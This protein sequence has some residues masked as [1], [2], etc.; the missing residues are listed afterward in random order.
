MVPSM[1]GGVAMHRSG[2]SLGSK[3]YVFL[4]C[5]FVTAVV[6]TLGLTVRPCAYATEPNSPHGCEV[7]IHI[8]PYY[9]MDAILVE[10]D[11]HFG[12]IDSGED[13]LYPNG[14]DGYILREGV[15][16]SAG[17]EREL[18]AYM[19]SVGV[20]RGN[21]DFYIGTHAHSDHIGT[22]PFVLAEFQP[23]AVYTPYYADE[24][25]SNKEKLWDNLYVYDK[26]CAAVEAY[27]GKLVHYL[28]PAWNGEG[29]SGDGADDDRSSQT[30]RPSFV[31]GDAVVEIMNYESADLDYGTFAAPDANNYSYGVK[32]IAPN[33][34][35]AFLSGDINDKRDVDEQI[36]GGDETRLAKVLQNVDFLKL[37]HHG[38]SGSNTPDY[39][40][41]ILRPYS[42]DERAVVVQTG[43]YYRLP[44]NTLNTLHSLGVRYFCA[45]HAAGLGLEAFVATLGDS[46]VSTNMDNAFTVQ[47]R[48]SAPWAYAYENGVPV[49]GERGFKSY[50]QSTYYFEDDGSVALGWR[51]VGDTWY[52]FD[53]S[54]GRRKT[55]WLKD[56]STWYFLDASG[57]MQTGWRKVNGSWYYLEG[58]G[59]MQTGWLQ[60]GSRW[61]YL[62]KS[63]A[64]AEGWQRNGG[65]WYYL[66]PGSGVMATGWIR[67]GGQWYYLKGSGAMAQGWQRVGG[68]WYYLNGS[69][70]MAEGWKK[71]SGTWYYLNPGS[72]TMATGWL[73]Y[74]GSWYYLNSSGAMS[75]GP[76]VIGGQVYRFS[77]SGAMM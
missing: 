22:A 62:G 24:L 48:K 27:G 55:G 39:L 26:L 36:G 72:G 12:M 21:L 44:A 52:Y 74:G 14:R 4:C 67:I 68:R 51:K 9:N 6:L 37:G 33:G 8:M 20:R 53:K 70:A 1:V 7:R 23:P 2:T 30:A 58:S 43:A 57:A 10:C 13:S 65:R 28:D 56:G 34:R 73:R 46:G 32:I 41:A 25:I 16:K 38:L 49:L 75:T 60:L 17:I 5:V 47:T 29:A 76:R 42:G 11:G 50:S 64:M 45:P 63:G 3:S 31:L 18:I 71:L 54:N 77:L 69:G 15:T 19:K 59:A 40:K 35:T 61:Y 66:R